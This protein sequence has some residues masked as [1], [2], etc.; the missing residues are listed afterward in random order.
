MNESERVRKAQE[1]DQAAMEAL[2]S[3]YQPRIYGYA[4]SRLRDSDEAEEICQE[5]FLKC[6]LSLKYLEK[7]EAFSA[8]LF[9]ICRNKV[10]SRARKRNKEPFI[11]SD[12]DER[13]EL[14]Q[15]FHEWQQYSEALRISIN[16][17]SDEQRDVARDHGLRR[18]RRRGAQPDLKLRAP[19]GRDHQHGRHRPVRVRG[20]PVHRPVL[21]RGPDL[22][23]CVG[24]E[25]PRCRRPGFRPGLRPRRL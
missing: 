20:G 15:S 12:I 6:F 3:S 18:E 4:F 11:D 24:Q 9:S 25:G 2:I 10:I 7:A 22:R 1:G 14:E 8:W 21:R 23:R 19:A 13:A 5:T 17:L 16:M